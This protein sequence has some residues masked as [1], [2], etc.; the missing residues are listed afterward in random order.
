MAGHA[1]VLEP[2][3]ALRGQIDRVLQGAGWSVDMAVSS[4]EVV[5]VAEGRRPDVVAMDVRSLQAP[6]LI[7]AEL[8]IRCGRRLPI[9]VMSSVHDDHLADDVGAFDVVVLPSEVDELPAR[10]QRGNEHR[11][12]SEPAATRHSRRSGITASSKTWRYK[13]LRSVDGV[14]YE[15][16]NQIDASGRRSFR[17]HADLLG[18]AGW[19]LV[20]VAVNE[21]VF[22][23][24]VTRRASQPDREPA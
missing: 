1:L 4:S 19:E 7:A 13:T 18:Q 10:L 14:I 9:M 6:R 15:D 3:P 11:M 17:E 23:R 12:D 5:A 22:K 8:R 2:D 24:E 20:G 16:G 21:W